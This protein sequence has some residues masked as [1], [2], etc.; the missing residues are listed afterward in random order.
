MSF[1]Q[2]R[3]RL[4]RFLQTADPATIPSEAIRIDLYDDAEY[5]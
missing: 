2:R 3:W 1:G 5:T 4:W